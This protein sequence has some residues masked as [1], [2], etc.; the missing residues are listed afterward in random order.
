MTRA[1]GPALPRRVKVVLVVFAT[2]VAGCSVDVVAPLPAHSFGPDI[3][4]LAF[5]GEL[6]YAAPC[7]FLDAGGMTL[8]ILWPTGYRLRGEPPAVTTGPRFPASVTRCASAASPRP[9]RS[10]RQDVRSGTAFF[11][12]SA[13]R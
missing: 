5:E 9:I 7:L 10:P 3:D 4:S 1:G 6:A 12:A 13:D 8:N 2:S 11:S